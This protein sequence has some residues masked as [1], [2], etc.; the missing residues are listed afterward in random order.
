ML[1]RKNTHQLNIFVA[2]LKAGQR[3][4]QMR[5]ISMKNHVICGL[6]SFLFCQY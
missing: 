1:I 6:Y 3:I 4:Q 2:Q 5:K